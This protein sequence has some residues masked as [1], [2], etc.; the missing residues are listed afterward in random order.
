MCLVSTRSRVR[1]SLEAVWGRWS[2]G[3]ILPSGG[4]GRGFDSR[5]APQV[6]VLVFV[7]FGSTDRGSQ[8]PPS[9]RRGLQRI[10][11]AEAR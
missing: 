1:S 5:T 2:R 10:G 7:F 6:L 4:R 9:G 8:L 3:M 11:A